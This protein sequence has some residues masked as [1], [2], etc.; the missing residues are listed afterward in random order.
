MVLNIPSSVARGS[1]GKLLQP[2]IIKDEKAIT[3]VTEVPT[4]RV[5]L[6]LAHSVENRDRE[7]L[8]RGMF[9]FYPIWTMLMPPNMIWKLYGQIE[10][11]KSA[12][13]G[14]FNVR[15]V[16]A[17]ILAYLFAKF[18]LTAKQQKRKMRQQVYY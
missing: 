5:R 4:D 18:G 15:L 1:S 17:F 11:I 16:E 14:R 12:L 2:L 13:S 10:D 9:N 7:S 3:P 6:T 8:V